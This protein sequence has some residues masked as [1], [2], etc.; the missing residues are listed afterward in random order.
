MK[1]ENK[2]K[3]IMVN[4]SDESKTRINELK[5]QLELTDK[6]FITVALEIFSAAKSEDIQAV[7]EKFSIEKQKAKIEARLAKITSQLEKAKGELEA[8]GTETETSNEAEA[9]TETS[10]EEEVLYNSADEEEEAVA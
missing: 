10:E 6:E 3:Q 5:E 7:V 1:T 2:T 4:V 8:V 9:E